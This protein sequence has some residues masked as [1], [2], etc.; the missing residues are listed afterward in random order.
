MIIDIIDILKFYLFFNSIDNG[1]IRIRCPCSNTD[2]LWY[3]T[4]TLY[5]TR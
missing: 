4:D 2:A 3:N 1:G 5:T